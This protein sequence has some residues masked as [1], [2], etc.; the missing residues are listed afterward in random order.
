MHLNTATF[1]RSKGKDHWKKGSFMLTRQ[2][3]TEAKARINGKKGYTREIIDD[4]LKAL[5]LATRRIVSEGILWKHLHE[6]MVF[7]YHDTWTYLQLYLIRKAHYTWL[8]NL[9]LDLKKYG[10]EEAK[11]M[12]REAMDEVWGHAQK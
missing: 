3:L 11:K 12:I 4:W 8:K 7:L 10:K 6:L 5:L 1:N 2:P 9:E